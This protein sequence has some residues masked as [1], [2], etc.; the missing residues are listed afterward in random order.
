VAARGHGALPKAL[1][2]SQ[3]VCASVQIA[4]PFQPALLTQ[5]LLLNVKHVTALI[6]VCCCDAML[7]CTFGTSAVG[8]KLGALS[9]IVLALVFIYS[10]SSPSNKSSNCP[11]KYS[12]C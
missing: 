6:S 10:F 1:L 3:H 4:A 2:L 8:Q 12:G 9:V 5:A 7:I 11:L